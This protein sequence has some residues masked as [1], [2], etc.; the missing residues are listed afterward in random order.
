[1][2]IKSRLWCYGVT[3]WFSSLTLRSNGLM[4]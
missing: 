1:M 3:C 4:A 2:Y